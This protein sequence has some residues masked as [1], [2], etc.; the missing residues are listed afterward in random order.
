MKDV[1]LV[2]RLVFSSASMLFCSIT[3]ASCFS[4][5]ISARAWAV[6]L[7]ACKQALR[8]RLTEKN[9]GFEA[10]RPGFLIIFM[11]FHQVFIAFS[12]VF[13]GFGTEVPQR[14]RLLQLCC[15]A[16]RLFKASKL[17]ATDHILQ[18]LLKNCPKAAEGCRNLSFNAQNSSCG[19]L[20]PVFTALSVGS[21]GSRLLFF[22]AGCRMDITLRRRSSRSDSWTSL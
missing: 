20:L 4:R 16:L 10:K 14:T 17:D 9:D 6:R 1:F 2:F 22:S 5:P 15:E 11:V 7:R 18:K 8:R 13:G 19:A 12:H 3:C 21:P